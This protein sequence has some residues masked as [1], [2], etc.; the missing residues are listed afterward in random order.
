MEIQLPIASDICV[1]FFFSQR[2]SSKIFFHWLLFFFLPIQNQHNTSGSSLND[3]HLF[4]VLLVEKFI[5]SCKTSKLAMYYY[6]VL[7]ILLDCV[8]SQNMGT[9]FTLSNIGMQFSLINPVQLLDTITSSSLIQCAFACIMFLSNCRTFQFDS[10]TLQCSLVE[11]D[12]TTGQIIPS[13]SSSKS[14][15]GT[16]NLI[17]EM[18]TS[19]GQ[20][21][22]QCDDNGLFTCINN[23]CQCSGHSY[24]DGFICKLQQFT[25]AECNST[26]GCRTDLNLTCLQSFLCGRK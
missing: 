7:I 15:V 24:F 26:N 17:P 3:F 20:L 21:C 16:M 5:F 11:G 4:F 9:L 23:T 2:F 8:H 25:G 22:S 1:S 12:L 19:Y 14:I 13:T 6:L 18:F 10:S